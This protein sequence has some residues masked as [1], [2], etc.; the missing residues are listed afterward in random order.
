MDRL[1]LQATVEELESVLRK[2][3]A[4][5]FVLAQLREGLKSCRT[6]RAKQLLR[7]VEGLLSG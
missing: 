6:D 2:H 5:R 3:T 7:E 1:Y 4:K